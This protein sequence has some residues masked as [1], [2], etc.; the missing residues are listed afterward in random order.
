M[1]LLSMAC[2]CELTVFDAHNNNVVAFDVIVEPMVTTAGSCK[3]TMPQNS[4]LG[5]DLD[6]SLYTLP[7]D[8]YD[9][10]TVRCGTRTRGRGRQAISRHRWG[11]EGDTLS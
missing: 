7:P 11:K 5:T 10:S 2:S 4:V 6:S 1:T 8:F 3:W 9:A